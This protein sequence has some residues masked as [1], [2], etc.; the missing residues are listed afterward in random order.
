MSNLISTIAHDFTY[1]DIEKLQ[2]GLGLVSEAL[3]NDNLTAYSKETGQLAYT[4]QALTLNAMASGL[5][6]ALSSQNKMIDKIAQ[7]LKEHYEAINETEFW[8]VKAEGLM[9][10]LAVCE[11]NLDALDQAYAVVKV[12]YEN[13]TGDAWRPYTPKDKTSTATQ[14]ATSLDVASVLKKYKLV[15]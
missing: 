14:T 13:S 1:V 2:E 12:L 11:H 4:C 5:H 3:P 8:N 15:A 7:D 6:Y 9:E 10:R